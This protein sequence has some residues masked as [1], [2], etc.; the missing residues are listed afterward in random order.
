VTSILAARRRTALGLGRS[1]PRGVCLSV[2]LLLSSPRQPGT[3]ICCLFPKLRRAFA[4]APVQLRERDQ[5]AGGCARRFRAPTTMRPSRRV[6]YQRRERPIAAFWADLAATNSCRAPQ[7]SALHVKICCEPGTRAG[8]CIGACTAR[9]SAAH[10]HSGRRYIAI[11]GPLAPDGGGGR[12]G[13]QGIASRPD[14]IWHEANCGRDSRVAL[15]CHGGREQGR[16]RPLRE[17]GHRL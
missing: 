10:W 13:T 12:L 8:H 4:I 9:R 7:W 11:H 16:R 14:V 6:R 1:I 5:R 15:P 2:Q 3:Q 17:R